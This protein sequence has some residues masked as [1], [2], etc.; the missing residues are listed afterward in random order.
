MMHRW[1]FCRA[2]S[3]AVSLFAAGAIAETTLDWRFDTSGR[4]S[5]IVAPDI[6]PATLSA[7]FETAFWD[8]V[9]SDAISVSTCRTGM[10]LIVM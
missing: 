9:E 1:K 4:A 2:L 7:G 10:L 6:R 3:L 5:K 8:C